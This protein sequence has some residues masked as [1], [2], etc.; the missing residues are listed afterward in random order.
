MAASADLEPSV[1]TRITPV[2]LLAL[3]SPGVMASSLLSALPHCRGSRRGRHRGAGGTRL[4]L[5]RNANRWSTGCAASQ[6]GRRWS[7]ARYAVVWREG[8]LRPATGKLDLRP[9]R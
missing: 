8:T 7:D 6:P 9:R 1:A 5:S 3:V 4:R 2:K